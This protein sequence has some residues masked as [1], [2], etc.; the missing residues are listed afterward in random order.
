MDTTLVVQFK[1]ML[2]HFYCRERKQ[3]VQQNKPLPT[4]VSTI[5]A[6]NK[7]Q[8]SLLALFSRT[9]AVAL[10]L[11]PPDHVTVS[12]VSCTNAIP[13]LAL[14]LSQLPSCCSP[15]ARVPCMLCQTAPRK[16][17]CLWLLP[18]IHID[19]SGGWNPGPWS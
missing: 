15:Q 2:A 12:L 13:L 6:K 8:F 7:V 4:Q 19:S 16:H 14:S 3:N 1:G 5:N 9:A 17:S 18:L 10:C 11:V